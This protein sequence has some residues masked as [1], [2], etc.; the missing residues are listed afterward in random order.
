[1]DVVV[2]ITLATPAVPAGVVAVI[3]VSLTTT[4]L[5]AAAPPMITAVALVKPLPVIVTNV[6]PAVEPVAGEILVTVVAA[7]TGKQIPA[8]TSRTMHPMKRVSCRVTGYHLVFHRQ[9]CNP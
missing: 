1:M 5:V 3:E 9:F 7:D 8:K 6:S 2:T 4:T